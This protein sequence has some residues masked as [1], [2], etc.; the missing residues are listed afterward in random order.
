MSAAMPSTRGGVLVRARSVAE[1]TSGTS[2]DRLIGR[3]T[4]VPRQASVIESPS[5]ASC[6]DLPP[7]VLVRSVAAALYASESANNFRWHSAQFRIIAADADHRVRGDALSASSACVPM[8]S[9]VQSSGRPTPRL[10]RL[11]LLRLLRRSCPP[12]DFFNSTKKS[13]DKKANYKII[14]IFE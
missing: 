1:R 8:A 7:A 3:Q 5:S 11:A 6:I 12:S 9:D 13:I 2:L 14:F 10:G 4:E